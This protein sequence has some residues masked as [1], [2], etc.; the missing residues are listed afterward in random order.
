MTGCEPYNDIHRSSGPAPSPPDDHPYSMRASVRQAVNDIVEYSRDDLLSFGWLASIVRHAVGD[1]PE[2]WTAA[3]PRVREHPEY[4]FT[5]AL[6]FMEQ[7]LL[8]AGHWEGG[9]DGR[10]VASDEPLTSLI[11]RM[12]VEYDAVPRDRPLLHGDVADFELT[13]LGRQQH[14]DGS[15]MLDE[16]AAVLDDDWSQIDWRY[17]R[18]RPP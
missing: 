9:A 13:Q 11:A 2:D 12:R 10:F 7:G 3:P 18:N 4:V 8:T 14:R 5:A 15:L 6:R 16:L 1:P 17:R